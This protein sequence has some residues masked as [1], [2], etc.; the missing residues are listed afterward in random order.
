MLLVA[1]RR[2]V[3][4]L[5]LFCVHAAIAGWFGDIFSTEKGGFFE[6]QGRT[7]VMK[8]SDRSFE[9]E[10]HFGDRNAFVQFYTSFCSDCRTFHPLWRQVAKHFEN[11]TNVLIASV[12]CTPGRSKNLCQKKQ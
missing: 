9:E 5:L 11:S 12:D 3:A 4:L 7:H 10:V 1:S 2:L 8:L 6:K